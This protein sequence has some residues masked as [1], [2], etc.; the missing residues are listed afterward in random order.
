MQRPAWGYYF[1]VLVLLVLG[2]VGVY[3]SREYRDGKIN[4]GQHRHPAVQHGHRRGTRVRGGRVRQAPAAHQDHQE[5]LRHHHQGDGV[6]YINPKNKSAAG[7]NATL[8]KFASSIGITLNAGEIEM[9]GG[10]LYQ[11]GD[12]CEGKPGH[13]YVMTWADPRPRCRT[14]SCRTPRKNS[15]RRRRGATRTPA[16][17][18]ATSGVLLEND[19]LVTIAFLPAPAKGK[20]LSVLQPSAA[21]VAQLTKLVAGP[22]PRRLRRSP[23]PRRRQRLSRLQQRHQARPPPRP[24]LSL[25]KPQLRL[26][27]R[28]RRRRRGRG[29]RPPVRPRRQRGRHYGHH[30]GKGAEHDGHHH[31]VS[32]QAK[33]ARTGR[34]SPAGLGSSARP[35]WTG[36]WPRG[37]PLTWWTTCRRVRWPTWPRPGQR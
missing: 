13:V 3:N 17:P 16:T 8:G 19:Q 21:V 9:P 14:A 10:R 34:W 4:G 30:Q 29:P 37:T 24:Q 27:G 2:V 35:W 18:T 26:R 11:D 6:I 20:T 1:A 36:Y 31:E 25:A 33:R 15:R 32:S 22:R 23:R 12:T 7:K 28:R 5:P